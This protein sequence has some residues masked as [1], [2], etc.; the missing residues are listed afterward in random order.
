MELFYSFLSKKLAT[1]SSEALKMARFDLAM[2]KE[3]VRYDKLLKVENEKLQND[4]E[5]FMAEKEAFQM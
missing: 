2:A 3:M 5:E 4:I 1:A